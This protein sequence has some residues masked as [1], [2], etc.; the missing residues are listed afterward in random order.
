MCSAPTH[1]MKYHYL[2]Q[3]EFNDNYYLL[4]YEYYCMEKVENCKI[5]WAAQLLLNKAM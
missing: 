3:Y 1:N 4:Q 2:L 5:I